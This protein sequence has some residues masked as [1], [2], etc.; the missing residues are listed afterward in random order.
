MVQPET[1]QNTKPKWRRKKRKKKKKQLENLFA[2][3]ANN[4][5]DNFHFVGVCFIFVGVFGLNVSALQNITSRVIECTLC[6]H[7][8]Q[9]SEFVSLP[10]LFLFHFVLFV[11]LNTGEKKKKKLEP[12]D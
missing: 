6:A 10:P 2:P 1:K 11:S 9:R 12:I 3:S 7:S 8:V 5:A 4:S